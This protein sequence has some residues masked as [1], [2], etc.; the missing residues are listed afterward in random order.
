MPGAHHVPRV[1]SQV[2]GLSDVDSV[3]LLL[4]QEC[5]YLDV[6]TRLL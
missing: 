4:A 6:V 3:D 5:E 1:Q 2:N